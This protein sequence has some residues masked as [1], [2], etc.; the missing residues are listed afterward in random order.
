MSML[1]SSSLAGGGR[2][3]GVN[4]GMSASEVCA[5]LDPSSSPSLIASARG[6]RRGGRAMLGTARDALEAYER[7]E[8]CE[9]LRA[10]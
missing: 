2:G 10:W 3:E 1:A 7:V 5:R 4:R 8:D 6:E 9:S